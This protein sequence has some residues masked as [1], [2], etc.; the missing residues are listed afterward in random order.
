MKRA[1]RIPEKIYTLPE[2]KKMTRIWQMSS[3]SVAFTNGVFDLL[4]AGHIK[5]LS[6]AAAE[7]RVLVVALNSDA[8]VKR[9]KGKERPVNDQDARALIMA[10][11]VMVDAVVIFDEDTP[12][13]L[14][15]EILPDVIIK[16]GDYT[17]ENVVGSKEVKDNGGRV[18]IV[19]LEDGLST[20]A[21]IEK[22][23]KQ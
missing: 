6:E 11:L 13:E 8:S 15:K 18:V 23:R 17:E 9:L 19:P 14:I 2:L 22:I 7:G 21:I 16:G 10:S 12:L 3:R 5:L 20:S 4:H 1:D